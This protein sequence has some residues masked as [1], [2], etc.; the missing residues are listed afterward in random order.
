MRNEQVKWKKLCVTTK[1]TV[2]IDKQEIGTEG[3][4]KWIRRGFVNLW[5]HQEESTYSVRLL[6]SILEVK[7]CATV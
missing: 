4:V 6:F 3:D 2:V 7:D 1:L 5:P